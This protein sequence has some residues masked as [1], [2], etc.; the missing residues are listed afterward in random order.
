MQTLE[1]FEILP[2]DEGL[3]TNDLKIENGFKF[4]V[5]QDRSEM[6]RLG[7]LF[8]EAGCGI[9]TKYVVQSVRKSTHVFSA[10]FPIRRENGE[11]YIVP[12][13]IAFVR[14]DKDTKNFTLEII[15]AS[16]DMVLPGLNNKE[17][18]LADFWTKYPKILLGIED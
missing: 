4:T 2:Q 12:I 6:E 8:V 17:L 14:A 7:F 9:P 18:A 3:G 1:N 11:K 10:T 5:S 15:F 13:S 16:G